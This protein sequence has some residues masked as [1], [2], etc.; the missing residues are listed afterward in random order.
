MSGAGSS[1][2]G[3]IRLEILR[4]LSASADGIAD[5]QA[6]AAAKGLNHL[7]VVGAT[8]SLEAKSMVLNEPHTREVLVLTEEALGYA[9]SGS[10]EFQVLNAIPSEGGATGA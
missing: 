1:A 9:K 8:K 10:P 4:A 3:D 5:T 7:A 6:F 2:S